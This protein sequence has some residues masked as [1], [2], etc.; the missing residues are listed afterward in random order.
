MRHERGCV[1]VELCCFV[2]VGHERSISLSVVVFEESRVDV[3]QRKPSTGAR[4]PG[5]CVPLFILVASDSLLATPPPESDYEEC[6]RKAMNVQCTVF[7][8]CMEK[9][10]TEEGMKETEEMYSGTDCVYCKHFC[11]NEDKVVDCVRKSTQSL[12][13]LSDTSVTMVPFGS[14]LVVE[15]ISA[16]CE[17]DA[18]IC[19]TQAA[20]EN[21]DCCQ[22]IHNECS[23]YHLMNFRNPYIVLSCGRENP[24]ESDPPTIE[25]ACQSLKDY[26]ACAGEKVIECST[27]MRDAVSVVTEKLRDS[28]NCK[29]FI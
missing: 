28:E 14:Q 15:F 6:S 5:T 3:A 29:N 22:R 25:M 4:Q 23:K 7:D 10:F 20:Q 17:K 12:K 1:I 27:D 24:A 26:M 13:N 9:I 2:V 11:R 16:L 19:L 21:I 8:K 18:K